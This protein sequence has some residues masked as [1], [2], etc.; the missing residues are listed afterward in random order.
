MYMYV[1][2]AQ[3]VSN[4]RTTVCIW[5][6]YIDMFVL[7]LMLRAYPPRSL[8]LLMADGDRIVES[9]KVRVELM[10]L[11]VITDHVSVRSGSPRSTVWWA[12]Q[13]TF[14]CLCSTKV[15]LVGEKEG[16]EANMRYSCTRS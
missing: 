15:A 8:T 14:Q 9:F 1:L 13:D 2:Y 10:A 7:C 4:A 11:D 12:G 5:Y 3:G 6:A 16:E